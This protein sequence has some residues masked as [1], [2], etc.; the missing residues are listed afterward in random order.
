MEYPYLDFDRCWFRQ[1]SF[2]LA[3]E[4][5]S[6]M[7]GFASLQCANIMTLVYRGAIDLMLYSREE[8]MRSIGFISLSF[9]VYI[10]IYTHMYIYIYI[11]LS[12]YTYIHT[13]INTY[14]CIYIYI[15]VYTYTHI[16]HCELF[17]VIFVSLQS[18]MYVVSVS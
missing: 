2:V 1:V 4:Q 3:P 8:A 17:H 6:R 18:W 5:A 9:Y 16:C 10:Y 15:Y 7:D 12:I 11:Y 14:I 13:H